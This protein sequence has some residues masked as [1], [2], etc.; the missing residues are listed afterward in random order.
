MR[1]EHLYVHVPFCA[2]RCVYCDFSIAVRS[3]VPADDYLRGLERELTRRHADSEFELATLYFGGGTPSKLGGDGVARMMEMLSR[4][5][6][7]RPQAEVTLEAN[8]EDVTV[9]AAT[10]WRQAGVNRVSLG[11][12]SLDAAVLSWMH[13]THDADAALRAVDV[14]REVGMTNI[15]ID[16]IFGVPPHLKRRWSQEVERVVELGVSHVSV[17]GL[18]VEPH[19]PLGRW[20]AREDVAE[21]PEEEFEHE[22]LHAHD[23]FAAAGFEHYEVSNYGMPGRHSRHNWAYWQRRSYAG[24][25]PAAHEFD[26]AERRWNVAPYATWLA[27]LDQGRSAQAGSERLDVGD[28]QSEELY[29]RLRT[30]AGVELAEPERSD[31]VPWLEAGWVELHGNNLRLTAR[32]WLRLDALANHLTLL[33]SRSYI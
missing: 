30:S 7:L 1:F 27:R 8:P 33:R 15:S 11:V 18:T 22:F 2:R 19:T 24:L 10:S 5:I 20:V 3:R 4:R 29:L 9:A 28:V 25:G 23:S 26:G 12:Q 21:A 32:G 6:Q 16:L 14:L 13:R 17:Y 31:V